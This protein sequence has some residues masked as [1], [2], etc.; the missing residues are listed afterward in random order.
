MGIGKKIQFKRLSYKIGML[1]I[2]TEFVALFALGVFYINSFTSQIEKGLKQN[3]QTPAY[4]MSKG[5][6]RYESAEDKIIME[7][8]VGETIEECIIVGANGN[9]YF[10]LKPENNGKAKDEVPILTQYEALNQEIESDVFLNVNNEEGQFFVTI[11]PL[12]L[13]DGKFLGHLFIYA[14]MERVQQ[15]KASIIWM[16]IIGSFLCIIL[17]SGV[18]IFL[19]NMNFTKNINKVLNRLT[20]I[21]G[22]KL[23]N[24]QLKINSSDEI[25]L[26]SKAINN[27]NDKLREIVTLISTGAIKVNGSSNQINNISIKVASG[28]SQQAS[29]AEEVSSAVEEMAAMIE[30]NTQNANETQSISIKAA[31]GIQQLLLKEEESLKYIED[32]SKKISI[33]NDIAF[34]T[35]ILALNAAVEAARA[36]EQGRGFAVVAGEV[37]RLAENSRVAADEITQL[38]EKAVSITTGTHDFMMKLAP[39]I[40]KTSQLVHDIA[41]SSS[42]QNN[43]AAQINSAI[44]ELNLVIQQYATTAE[45]MATNSKTLKTEAFELEQSILFF[46]IEK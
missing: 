22:G 6:L 13:E 40:E 33:V 30:N 7:K 26:L 19:F 18:I 37:R 27:L 10:S 35:N 36:G 17:T 34:Q 44:Q 3:F 41:V 45:D 39:E 1:I 12:R 24:S 2:V 43:G 29:S 46:N 38:S 25:G 32:I 21:Q 9:V 4:L 15:E 20:E 16:F 11:S 31:E 5:L 14:K 28:S 42:E 8:L 23:P